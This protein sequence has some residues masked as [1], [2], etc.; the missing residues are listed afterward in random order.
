MANVEAN[1]AYSE[2]LKQLDDLGRLV[3]NLVTDIRF[4][5]RRGEAMAAGAVTQAE[6]AFQ[7]FTSLANDLI[8]A[9]DAAHAIAAATGSRGAVYR[10]ARV[11]VVWG[12]A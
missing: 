12:E 10:D 4:G 6:E 3:A 7:T 9:Q 11:T 8:S 1:K 2:H 5:V